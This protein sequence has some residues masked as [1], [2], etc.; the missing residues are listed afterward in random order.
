MSKHLLNRRQFSARC[1]A[2]GLSIPASSALIAVQANA[3]VPDTGAESSPA[4]RTVKFPDGTIVPALGQGSWHLA[5]GR[6]RLF[7]EEE[8]MRTGTT[9]GM[10][11]IDTSR[12]YGDGR[13]ERFIGRAIAGQRDRVFLVS[14]VQED[15]IVKRGA[16]AIAAGEQ[17]VLAPKGDV[18]TR[19][20]EQSLARLGTDYL[21]LYLLHSPV[22]QR[23][24]SGVV[25]KFE[26][27]RA[28]GKIRSWG[29]SNFNVDQMEE[30][31]RVP[32]GHRCATNQVRYSL[33]NRA[34]ERDVLPW[35]AQHNMPVMASSPLGGIE[36]ARQ[37]LGERTLVEL[38]S[39]HGCP[40]AAVA[41][42]FV[43]RSGN[44]I[45]IPESG[46]PEHVKEN[47][48]ALS[49]GWIPATG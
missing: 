13:S 43:M 2:L 47:A 23:Y 6:H 26:Q 30:L 24:L 9:L 35:C 32:D 37:L 41:L 27:L 18:I 21:D 16:V 1:A 28:A 22:P 45:A 36:Y 25:A 20:C 14:K 4:P 31:F 38:G 29:V 49:I 12:N 33:R 44:V 7:L 8:A 39:T 17:V 42:A 15:E 40:A 19:L 10:T 11:V 34:I 48:V 3:Q 5:Q 46:N